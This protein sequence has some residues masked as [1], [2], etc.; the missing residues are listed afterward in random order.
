MNTTPGFDRSAF[1][2]V[3]AFA[4]H[5]GWLHEPARLYA[6]D[7]IVLFA[8][9]LL[10]CWWRARDLGERAVARALWSPVAVLVAIGINQPLVHRIDEARPFTALPDVLVLVHRST[11]GAF[12][13]DH[14]TMAGA[15]LAGVLLST[16]RGAHGRGAR[17]FGIVTAVLAALMAFARVYVGVHYP[18]DVVAGLVLGALVATAV[19][20]PLGALSLPL[21]RRLEQTRL[22]P[23]LT[24]AAA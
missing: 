20:L 12:P 17:A 8:V 7:G 11:D 19:V 1:L 24:T 3:N 23:L 6:N 10:V 16:W 4:R 9:L 22:R 5:T 2:H 15:V 13:S 14:G 21:V 18:L